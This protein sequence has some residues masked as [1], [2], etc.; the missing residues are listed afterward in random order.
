VLATADGVL[1]AIVKNEGDTVLSDEVL[2][3]IVEGGAAAAAPAA[4][5]PAAARLLLQLPKAKTIRSLLQPLASWLKR[6]AS[7]SRPLPVLAKAVV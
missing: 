1:G 3:S 4:A 2:G 5:A 7:T 6:T